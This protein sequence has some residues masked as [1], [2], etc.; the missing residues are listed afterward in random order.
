MLRLWPS[1]KMQDFAPVWALARLHAFEVL[2]NYW[3]GN[4]GQTGT[5]S[6]EHQ[7]PVSFRSHGLNPLFFTDNWCWPGATL[8]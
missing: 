5:F 6:S 8:P 7:H 2:R 1:V 4:R 3:T